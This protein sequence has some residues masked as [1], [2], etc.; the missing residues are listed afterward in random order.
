MEAKGMILIDTDI[1]IDSARGVADALGC[2]EQIERE[3]IPCISVITQMEMIVGCA[4]KNEL[5]MLNRFLLRFRIVYL[6]EE[7][8]REAVRLMDE[9]RLSHGLMIPD[10]LIAATAMVLDCGLAT[11]NQR[12]YKFIS[13]L[14]LSPYP[15]SFS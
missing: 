11:K 9:Y 4:N 12:D 6:D 8:S 3:S 2:L 10:A 1:L 5:R 7:I 14:D 13:G 15:A